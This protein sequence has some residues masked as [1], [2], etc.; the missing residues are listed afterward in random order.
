MVENSVV[1]A[2]NGARPRPGE[3]PGGGLVAC[4]AM[5]PAH[6]LGERLIA[7]QSGASRVDPDSTPGID[8]RKHAEQ[9]LPQLAEKLGALQ[10][11]LWAEGRRAL[12]LVLQGMD[13]SGKGGTVGHV[14]S[15]MNPA[16]V[17][18]A[19][20]KK[21]T[22]EELAHDFLWRIEKRLPGPG[23]VVVF[24]RSHYEDVLVTRVHALVEEPVWR[25]RYEEINAFERRL[26]AAGT[27]ILKCFLHIS[28]DEQR[29]RL[30]ARLDDPTKH[31]K[32]RE[33]DID[34]RALWQAYM[35][36]YDEAI[37]R[38]SDAAPWFVVPANHKW[39]RNW[40]VATLLQ[41]TLERIDPSYPPT[42]LDV[43]ALKRRLA[44]PN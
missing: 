29:Q 21:P 35:A 4:S 17:D 20:F 37:A 25:A 13:T 30:L 5:S 8:G 43:A 31:W 6:P 10:E 14:I 38:C 33:R 12:L 28:Y 19:A 27:T 16:G 44:P 42:D 39:Y 9:E 2:L 1:K 36:A 7:P 24:D 18:V 26:T 23:E 34:E 3:N 32:F 15:A 40:A 11:R 41:E 22:D